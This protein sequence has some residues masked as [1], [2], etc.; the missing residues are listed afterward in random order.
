MGYVAAQIFKRSN[1]RNSKCTCCCECKQNA[2]PKQIYEIEQRDK[3]WA[4]FRYTFV[5]NHVT[6]ALAASGIRTRE[7]AERIAAIYEEVQ[8]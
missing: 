3:D 7:A 6:K 1:E 4:V 2:K 8:P 5:S